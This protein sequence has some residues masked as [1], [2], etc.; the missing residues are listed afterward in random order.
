MTEERF[1]RPP[2]GLVRHPAD[3]RTLPGYMILFLLLGTVAVCSNEALGVVL[4]SL[5][6]GTLFACFLVLFAV[7][8]LAWLLRGHAAWQD[9][10]RRTDG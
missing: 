10:R 4:A 6:A 3:T 7:Y 2:V 9:Q 5:V 1:E 8:W